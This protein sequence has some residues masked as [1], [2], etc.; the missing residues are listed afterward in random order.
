VYKQKTTTRAD[1]KV[2]ARA[3]ELLNFTALPFSAAQLFIKSILQHFAPVWHHR[4]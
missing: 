1:I 2:L 4:V 3:E